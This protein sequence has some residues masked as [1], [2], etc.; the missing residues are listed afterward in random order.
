MFSEIPWFFSKTLNLILLSSARYFSIILIVSLF[1]PDLYS[2][3]STIQ[4]SQSEYVCAFIESIIALRYSAFV[5]YTGTTILNLCFTLKIHLFCCSSELS[6]GSFFFRHSL[7]FFSSSIFLLI[8]LA[9]VNRPFFLIFNITLL[10]IF[11]LHLH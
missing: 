10:I 6:S 11:T 7:Y 5:L 8:F 2:L 9:V 1:S 4:S 3:A